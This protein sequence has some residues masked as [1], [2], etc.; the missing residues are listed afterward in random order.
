MK[1]T[2]F[3]GAIAIATSLIS[4][5]PVQAQY[6]WTC[7]REY[8]SSVNLRSGPGRNYQI[9]A[10]VPNRSFVYLNSW[11]W[12]NDGMR[13]YRISSNGLIGWSRG[14]YLCADR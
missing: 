11:V 9:I 10:S 13:W 14:D 1:N 12:G 4:I 8:N 3:A 7:T 2:I 6:A 5:A